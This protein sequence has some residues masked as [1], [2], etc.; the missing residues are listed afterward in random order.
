MLIT[1]R[2]II[3]E[4]NK[5]EKLNANN[6]KIWYRKV[7]YI[8]EKRETLETSNH[9]MQESKQRNSA[10]HRRDKGA[11]MARKKKSS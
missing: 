1:T 3:I 7:Q 8:L 9:V 5:D 6:Y 4:L 11:Y 10:Q 2:N